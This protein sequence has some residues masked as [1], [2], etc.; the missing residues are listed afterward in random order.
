M[1]DIPYSVRDKN[2]RVNAIK[3]FNFAD[4]DTNE[5]FKKVDENNVGGT[6]ILSTQTSTVNKLRMLV[7][8]GIAKV[9]TGVL[10]GISTLANRTLHINVTGIPARGISILDNGE[11]SRVGIGVIEPEED[12]QVDGNIQID[13]ANNPRLKY[14]RTGG[15]PHALSEIG[16]ELDGT[17]GGDL[18]FS[19]KVVG[20]S[21]T[22]KLRINNVGAIG[23]AGATYGNVG[24]VLTSNGP[25][26]TV[27][28]NRPYFM[29]A[30]LVSNRDADTGPRL[31]GM[32]ETAWS[33]P[34]G[35][36]TGDWS[37]TND[38]WTC[39]QTGIYRITLQVEFESTSDNISFAL[40]FLRKNALPQVPP[41]GSVI[42]RSENFFGTNSSDTLKRATVNATSILEIQEDDTIR[43]DFGIAT[44]GGSLS[45]VNLKGSSG[46]DATF[47][48]I[49]RVL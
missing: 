44:E 42:L 4:I 13:G 3:G 15:S 37:D 11:T 48:I 38:E 29:K 16:S 31:Q 6:N 34:F 2:I 40:G 39:P 43:M 30:L 28:W 24:A 36:A 47:L 12:L 20:G 23:I 5:M 14:Q 10:E 8:S 41:G 1:S 27:S 21:V 7:G 35:G 49:E 45:D 9:S 26:A 32:T 46:G 33:T 19:T 25:S 18:Q 17:N 22:E